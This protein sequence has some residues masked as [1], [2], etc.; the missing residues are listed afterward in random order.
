MARDRDRSEDL[1]QPTT[2]SQDLGTAFFSSSPVSTSSGLDD[3]SAD[4]REDL[5][6]AC[7]RE[8]RADLALLLSD[9]EWRVQ[10]G[11]E[12]RSL[13]RLRSA[14]TPLNVRLRLR[15]TDRFGLGLSD[16]GTGE[17]IPPVTPT[18]GKFVDPL[19]IRIQTKQAQTSVDVLT[20]FPSR[21][22]TSDETAEFFR[23]RVEVVG[24]R[25]E[26]YIGGQGGVGRFMSTASTAT[27]MVKISEKLGQEKVMY[28][29]FSYESVLGEYFSAMY[30]EKVSRVIIDGVFDSHNYRAELWNSNLFDFEK[31]VESLFTYCHQAG[32]LQCPLYESTPDKICVRYFAVLDAVAHKPVPVPLAESPMVVTPRDLV[33]QLFAATYRPLLRYNTV[34]DVIRAIETGNQT[35]AWHSEN[36]VFSAI[37]CGDG[38]EHPYDA[39]TYCKYYENMVAESPH[40][41]PI[42]VIHYLQCAEWRISPKWRYTGPLA[43]NATA[44]PL[45][46]IAPRYDHLDSRDVIMDIALAGIVKQSFISIPEVEVQTTESISLDPNRRSRQGF[47]MASS[48]STGRSRFDDPRTTTVPISWL[49]TCTSPALFPATYRILRTKFFIGLHQLNKLKLETWVPT[50]HAQTGVHVRSTPA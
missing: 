27:D 43:A 50:L 5:W 3:Q 17:P 37:A 39:E 49:P 15:S 47:T 18:S 13:R 40:G 2:P 33:W 41:G 45:L 29:V 9:S 1:E 31:V 42:W 21:L 16:L 19:V 20:T 11:R 46:L 28:W 34:V 8:P 24:A 26:E 23:T 32:P 10:D 22:R 30:S 38:E 7:Q 12:T 35:A 48:S 36:E 4:D 44:S 14:I 6:A 25:C